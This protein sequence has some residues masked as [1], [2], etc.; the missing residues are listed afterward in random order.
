MPCENGIIVLEGEI[1]TCKTFLG[2]VG[3]KKVLWVS[4]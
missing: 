3:I 4:G 2:G 1:S